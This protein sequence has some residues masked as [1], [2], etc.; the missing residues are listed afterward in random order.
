MFLREKSRN[1]Q[2][3]KAMR[4]GRN[5]F[6]LVEITLVILI[7]S[8]LAA[9]GGLRYSAALELYQVQRTAERIVADLDASRHAA[10]SRNQNIVIAFDIANQRYTISGLINPDR[11][12]AGFAVSPSN[13]LHNTQLV[14]ANFGGDAVLQY[15]NYGLPDS[16]GVLTLRRGGAQR[17]V[18]VVA[19]TGAAVSP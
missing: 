3:S 4:N 7:L 10:R 6:S 12:S 2:C 5:G 15:N 8:I 14:S 17:T 13:D 16:G 18:T 9:A 1:M 19:G 11:K